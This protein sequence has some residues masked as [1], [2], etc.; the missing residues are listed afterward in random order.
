M[1]ADDGLVERNGRWTDLAVV[2]P[3]EQRG[4]DGRRD[5]AGQ[6]QRRSLMEVHL[7]AVGDGH[8]RL[9]IKGQGSLSD[10]R[11]GER[12]AR[13]TDDSET[14][15]VRP[16]RSAAQ[17]ALVVAGV[18]RR[19]RCVDSN[20]EKQRVTPGRWLGGSLRFTFDLQRPVGAVGHVE[21]A[22]ARVGRVR[23]RA[24]RQQVNVVVAHPRHLPSV[25]KTEK[26]QEN[27]QENRSTTGR[28][29]SSC[30]PPGRGR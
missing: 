15:D 25:N 28:L 6:V 22:E 2:A 27:R 11:R 4:V 3:E 17:L 23:V 14:D 12:R 9:Y 21:T 16:Q 24:D 30:R 20:E 10:R 29:P 8:V 18:V 1:E 5:D 7:A 13:L 19:G 26:R